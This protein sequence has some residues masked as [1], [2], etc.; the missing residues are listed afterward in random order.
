MAYRLQLVSGPALAVTGTFASGQPQVTSMSSTAGILVGSLVENSTYLQPDTL[1]A[2][3]DSST[4][5]TLTQNA[6][7]S[8][9]AIAFSIHNEPVTLAQAKLHARVDISADDPL[10]AGFITSARK[11][12]ELR[13]SQR[14]LT[15]VLDYF[16]DSWPWVGGYWNRTVRAQAVMGPMPYWLPS[17]TVG[18]LDLH[19]APLLGV[20]WV[21]YTDFNG[22]VQTIDPSLY[23]F[24]AFTPGSSIVGPSRIQPAFAQTWPIPRPTIDSINIRYTVGYGADYTAVPQNLKDAIKMMVSLWYRNRDIAGQVPEAIEKTLDNLCASSEHGAY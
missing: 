14:L 4:Q 11:Q 15:T 23:I 16:S 22:V 13:L 7:A 24:D 17:S 5:I 21:R 10:I 18:I 20:Q 19:G 3:V 8:G 1:V 2:S 6:Q 12:V 9:S